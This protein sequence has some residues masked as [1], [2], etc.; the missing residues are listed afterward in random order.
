[1]LY[2]NF[3]ATKAFQKMSIGIQIMTQT[4][5]MMRYVRHCKT[6]NIGHLSN[7]FKFCLTYEINPYM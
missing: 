4:N 5:L 3:S 6:E 2:S 7:E 1:M